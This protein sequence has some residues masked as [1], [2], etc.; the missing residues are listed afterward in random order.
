MNKLANILTYNYDT[1]LE[2][3]V[4]EILLERGF[5]FKEIPYAFWQGK[6]PG[7]SATFYHSG[8]LVLQGKE[9]QTWADV[10]SPSELIPGGTRFDKVV[11]SHP[12]EAN[13]WVGSDE[14]GKGDYFGPLVVCAARIER[15]HLPLLDELGVADCKTLSDKQILEMSAGLEAIA[16][17]DVISIRPP[18]YNELYNKIGRNLNKLMAWAHARALEN[19]LERSPE[20]PLAIVDRFTPNDRLDRALLER[21]RSL[22]LVQRP[23]A[24]DDP[25]VALASIVARARFLRDLRY[26]G[27]NVKHVLPK[28]AGP[29]VTM[30][31]KKLVKDLGPEALEQ[32]AKMHF[33]TTESVLPTTLGF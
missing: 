5:V 18:R 23:R 32:V 21:G 11:E 1:D 15:A 26:M 27:K 8:K 16:T 22:H 30:A 19:V 29:K 10:I 7:C 17:V 2:D 24:E 13:A 9:A 4:K 3:R 25:A 14:S 31:A 6:V 20:T 28:G 33:K 12:F